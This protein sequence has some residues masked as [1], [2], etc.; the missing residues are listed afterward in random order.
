VINATLTRDE[1]KNIM[2][3]G[4]SSQCVACC[5]NGGNCG[6]CK[7][8]VTGCAVFECNEDGFTCETV[9]CF[10]DDPCPLCKN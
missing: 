2:A 10:G 7:T 9:S 8:T 4:G 3:G 1:M 5:D 6:C